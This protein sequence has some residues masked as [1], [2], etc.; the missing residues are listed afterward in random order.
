MD[1]KRPDNLAVCDFHG[2]PQGSL[3]CRKAAT[4]G[5]RLYFPSEGRRAQDFFFARKKIRLL[6]PGLNPRSRV[7]EASTLTTRP[8]KPQMCTVLL[9]PGVN[10]IV[11]EN[12]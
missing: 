9:P 11:V 1:E 4:W 8:P 5:T 12:K 2:K 3:T 6:R 7:P 10:Q